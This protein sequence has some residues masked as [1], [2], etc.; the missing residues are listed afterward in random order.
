MAFFARCTFALLFALCLAQGAMAAPKDISVTAQT[1]ALYNDRNI[2]SA[3]GGVIVTF[4]DHSVSAAHAVLDLRSRI[5]ILYGGVIAKSGDTRI[6]GRAYQ[7]DT[8]TLQGQMLSASPASTFVG[9][10]PLV[11]AQQMLITPGVSLRFTAAT[12]SSANGSQPASTYLYPLLAANARNFG[13]TVAQGAAL[14]FPVRVRQ[15][16][17]WFVYGDGQ[18]DRYAGGIGASIEA[19]LANSNRG[20]IAFAAT[21]SQQYARYDLAALGEIR[22]GLTQTLNASRAPGVRFARYALTAFGRAGSIQGVV[23]Q[24]FASRSDDLIYSTPRFVIGRRFF[25][26]VVTDFGH[27]IHPYDFAISQD[28]RSGASIALSTQ[29]FHFAGASVSF[30]SSI[31]GTTYTYGRRSGNASIGAFITRSFAQIIQTSLGLTL[32]QYNDVI[33]PYPRS[34]QRTLS[35]SLGYRPH[36]PWSVFTAMN[37]AHDFPQFFGIGRGVF[38][39]SLALRIHRKKGV[40]FEVDG[41]YGVGGIGMNPRPTFGISLIH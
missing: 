39:Q 7:L 1:I 21:P 18:Y 19:H 35:F 33:G 11:T 26:S 37:Y 8:T 38:S 3:D 25:A 5:L 28:A 2:V 27:D 34:T 4:D 20:Y 14:E 13:P 6:F 15:S 30:A 23:A 36:A 40:S 16:S 41:S 12:V 17:R 24:N 22:P 32:A 10:T 29:A 9:T 31:G